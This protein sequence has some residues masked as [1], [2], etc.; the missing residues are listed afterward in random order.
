MFCKRPKRLSLKLYQNHLEKIQIIENDFLDEN[1]LQNIPQ[2]IDFAYYLV[3]SMSSG[4]GNFQKR[5]NFCRK[6][7]KSIRKNFSKTSR[8]PHWNYQ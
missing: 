4:S 7:Q 1:S 2:D 3:H 8:F 5:E 6:F